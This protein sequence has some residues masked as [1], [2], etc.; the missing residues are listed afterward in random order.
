MIADEI[1]ELKEILPL[2]QKYGITGREK[3]Q[4][5]LDLEVS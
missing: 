1:F 5:F 4:P 3:F 2:L